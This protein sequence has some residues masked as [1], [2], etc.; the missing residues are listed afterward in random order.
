MLRRVQRVLE[1]GPGPRQPRAQPALLGVEHCKLLLGPVAL[2]VR[3]D[4]L[5]LPP[6][7]Q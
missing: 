4:Q 7:C 6:A 3:A 1:V 2:V 5:D